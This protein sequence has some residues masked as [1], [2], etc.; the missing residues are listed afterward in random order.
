MAEQHD[1]PQR[2]PE[3]ILASGSG[4]RKKMLLDAGVKVRAR[5]ARVD[6]TPIKQAVQA[7]GGTALQ[8]AETLAE[9]KSL[10][11]SQLEPDA[12]CIGADQIL[13]CDGRWF[14]KPH[15]MAAARAHLQFMAGKTHFLRTAVVIS[16]HGRPIW[17]HIESPEI[18]M[19]PVSA[20]ALE[21]YLSLAGKDILSSVGA[22]H[23]E[24][25][26]AQ[27]FARVRGDYFTILGLPLLPVLDI[28][29]N[30]YVIMP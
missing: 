29:R 28:L 23:Y 24:G 12:L 11:V 27:L 14:D 16:Q 19:R 26:G 7:E 21:Q 8:A 25:L 30:H 18:V 4:I 2:A 3:V 6:E 1:S 10:R 13:E 20:A 5:P 15:D 9:M 22:Y 17:R